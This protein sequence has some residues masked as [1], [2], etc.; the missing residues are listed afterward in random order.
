MKLV[1]YTFENKRSVGKVVDGE[2]IDIASAYHGAPQSML[3]IMQGGEH[4]LDRIAA[5]SADDSHSHPL[6]SVRLEAPISNPQKFLA[7]GLNY[8]DHVDEIVSRGGKAPEHQIWFNKQ[9]SCITGPW[10]G[11]RVPRVSDRVDYEI[12]LGVVIGKRCRYIDPADALSVIGGY[13]V[14]NDVTARDWQR[15]T[16]QWTLGKS[17]DT[18]GPTG[19]WL[20]TPDDVPDPQALEMRLY[21]N[22]E[23]R[24]KTST[25]L[26]V[27]NIAAQISHLSQVMTLEPGDIL[28]TGTCAGAGWGMDPPR[29]LKPGDV[30]RCEID[31]IGHIENPIVSE[32]T[33]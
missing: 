21:V 19:P 14:I 10:D 1:T 5:I 26:M 8:Q 17:F 31:G 6:T 9:V 3:E 4:V 30:V 28:A 32:P 23:L 27:F 20:V 13:T 22:G 16:P 24:Q 11:V 33:P 2:V 25:A 18:H 7:I 12:E 15:M 29:F